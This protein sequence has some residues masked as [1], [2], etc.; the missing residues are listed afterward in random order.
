MSTL[1]AASKFSFILVS[2]MN[3]IT[4]AITFVK[5]N[6]IL[7]HILKNSPNKNLSIVYSNSIA[8]WYS[9]NFD[10]MLLSFLDVTL[11]FNITAFAI[12]SIVSK[13]MA[14]PTATN[15]PTTGAKNINNDVPI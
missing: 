7:N 1:K 14:T 6:G 11:S 3:I 12:P 2:S 10:T 13:A 15:I 4:I 8:D 5:K 9:T